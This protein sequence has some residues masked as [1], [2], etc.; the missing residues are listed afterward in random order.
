ML[1]NGQRQVLLW[2]GHEGK[3][4]DSLSWSGMAH[5]VLRKLKLLSVE[6]SGYSVGMSDRGVIHT[7]GLWRCGQPENQGIT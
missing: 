4:C 5:Q 7:P 1:L 6:Q 2:S 3:R